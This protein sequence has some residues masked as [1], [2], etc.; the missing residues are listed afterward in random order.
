M[1]EGRL[2]PRS[3]TGPGAA[4]RT[5][6]SLGGG[7]DSDSTS[8]LHVSNR[9]P[10]GS[11]SSPK[12]N[13]ST[14]SNSSNSRWRH[15]LL[16]PALRHLTTQ[17]ISVFVVENISVNVF[18]RA[19]LAEIEASASKFT[20]AVT[21]IADDWKGCVDAFI[22][23]RAF[24]SF[25]GMIPRPHSDLV[26]LQAAFALVHDPALRDAGLALSAA[27]ATGPATVGF[28]G[29]VAGRST[30]LFGSA[31]SDARALLNVA[32]T[33]GSPL[34]FF[35]STVRNAARQAQRSHA[36]GMSSTWRDS[37]ERGT[38]PHPS[39]SSQPHI[40][41]AQ[42]QQSGRPVDAPDAFAGAATTDA[43]Q[44]L[45]TNMQPPGGDDEPPPIVNF[46]L[47][48]E[49]GGP[50]T[51]HAAKDGHHA[52]AGGSGVAGLSCGAT[53]GNPTSGTS[54][55]TSTFFYALA[56]SLPDAVFRIVG[57]ASRVGADSGASHRQLC[58]ALSLRV[59]QSQLWA[60]V[61]RVKRKAQQ[62]LQKESIARF[63]GGGGGLAGSPCGNA[64]STGTTAP[65]SV[66]GAKSDG[67]ESG[68]MWRLRRVVYRDPTAPP[69]SAAASTVAGGGDLQLSPTTPGLALT[70]FN[71]SNNASGTRELGIT[72]P[73]ASHGGAL[74]NNTTGLFFR[75]GSMA[76]TSSGVW[77]SQQQRRQSATIYNEKR[78]R[79]AYDQYNALY[80]RVAEG[81]LHSRER[82]EGDAGTAAIAI[83]ESEL[84]SRDGA[85][86]CTLHPAHVR[87]LRQLVDAGYVPLIT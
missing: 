2:P 18:G 51:S 28:T 35:E 49:I 17:E 85:G 65:I 56:S 12:L 61:E 37:L 82:E 87:Q 76:A 86:V 40:P 66:S 53:G 32:L 24:V 70:S 22:G 26:S 6:G 68:G 19:A 38:P 27:C 43:P 10:D 31:I 74:S 8:P 54:L 63:G 16:R 21:K 64:G 62:E 57:I 36:L 80:E 44:L 13:T 71:T 48:F 52:T 67:A 78:I 29:R 73:A 23:D 55:P 9:G 58:E 83:A 4:G 79:S 1:S 60:R 72:P 33:H 47:G 5:G 34:L 14:M 50:R 25:N 20:D 45:S 69:R 59:L 7:G 39:S 11:S 84:L 3:P 30:V 77:T 75:S 81:Q 46:N 15:V 42:Q 41:S